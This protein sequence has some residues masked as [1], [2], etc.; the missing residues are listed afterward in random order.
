MKRSAAALAASLMLGAAT[1]ALAQASAP[2]NADPWEPANRFG[3]SIFMAVDRVVM[4]PAA[5]VYERVLPKVVRTGVHNMLVNLGEPVVGMN[6]VFQGRFKQAAKTTV[7]FVADSTVGVGGMIDVGAKTGLPHH[8]NGFDL[9]LG[10]YRV[11]SG[12]YVFLPILGPSSVRDLFGICVDSVIDPLHW[13][14]Y[15]GRTALGVSRTLVGGVD[16]RAVNDAAF[17]A[18]ISD[19]T[20]PYATLRSVYLQNQQSKIDEGKPP[21]DQP[22]P[23]F[24]EEKPAPAP[25]PQAE[26]AP[27]PEAVTEAAGADVADAPALDKTAAARDRTLDRL[28]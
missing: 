15:P 10:R 23:D 22:L 5:K 16:T 21:T 13:V 9:T 8:D 24:D 1:N 28:F 14:N 17:E 27:A 20:D 3:F 18:L 12:P 19:A 25:Q 2:A 6:D 4:R 26:A 7:R 11:K